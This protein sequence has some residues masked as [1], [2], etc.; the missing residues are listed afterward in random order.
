M[1]P[2]GTN[3]IHGLANPATAEEAKK[4][5]PNVQGITVYVQPTSGRQSDSPGRS[6]GLE[7]ARR[8]SAG[9]NS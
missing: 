7:R 8:Q 5:Y 2:T 4:F 9:A 1:R 3:T 6:R